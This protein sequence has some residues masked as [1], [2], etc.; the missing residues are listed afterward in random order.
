MVQYGD[1]EIEIQIQN[2]INALSV[3]LSCA[4]I[5][6]FVPE[7][8]LLKICKYAQ[9]YCDNT[10]ITILLLFHQAFHILSV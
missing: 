4:L 1:F 5:A 3:A 6:P 7:I 8:P 9:C 2:T 10:V